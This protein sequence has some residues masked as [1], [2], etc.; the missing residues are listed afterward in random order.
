M[1]SVLYVADSGYPTLDSVAVRGLL[2]REKNLKS[3]ADVYRSFMK[4]KKFKK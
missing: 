1:D 4:T 3:G 2:G